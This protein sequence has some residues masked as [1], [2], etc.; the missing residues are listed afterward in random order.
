MG[1]SFES[2]IKTIFDQ[3]M[4]TDLSLTNPSYILS[5]KL[6]VLLKVLTTIFE[7]ASLDLSSMLAPID[8]VTANAR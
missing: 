5:S 3:L 1:V 7:K 2:N 6:H 8:Q 4:K